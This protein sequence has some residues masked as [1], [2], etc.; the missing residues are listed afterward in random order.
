MIV[1]ANCLTL[2]PDKGATQVIQLIAKWLGQHSETFVD[3]ERL[4]EGIRDLRLKDDRITSRATLDSERRPVFPY[5]FCV[6]L[7]HKD[8]ETRGRKW[9]TELGLQQ[10]SSGMPIACSILLKTDEVSARVLTPI[11]VTR[12][13]IVLDLVQQCRAISGTPGMAVKRLTEE[14]ATGYSMEIDRTDRKHPIVVVS[15]EGN[16]DY[17]VEPDRLRKVLI[18]LADIVQIPSTV[19][20]FELERKI[21]RRYTAFGGAITIVFPTRDTGRG[22]YCETVLLKTDHL[23]QVLKD[24]GSIESEVLGSVTHRTNLPHSWRH[25]SLESVS[26]ASLRGQMAG[27][28]SRLSEAAKATDKSHTLTAELDKYRELLEQ[29]FN[30]MT[31]KDNSIASLQSALDE[32]QS[33]NRKLKADNDGL[34]FTLSGQ[35]A[36][37]YEQE[38]E[39][40]EAMKP[41][42]DAFRAVLHDQPTLVQCLETIQTLF[43]DRVRVLNSAFDSAR[44]SDRRG[45]KNG[46]RAFHLLENLCGAYWEALSSGKGDQQAKARFG[47]DGYAAVESAKLS[48]EGKKR[49][50]FFYRGSDIFM[51]KHLRDGVKDSLGETLRIHFEWIAPE[52]KI[53]IG[54][55]GKH[56]DF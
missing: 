23:K 27:A 8:L 38:D 50:T 26:E 56:L 55:C 51:E 13:R 42:R 52:K 10:Q 9:I 31:E 28:I 53:V 6:R 5:S 33:L 19:N 49:R 4:A 22:A 7:S 37:E 43:G 39:L 35:Q 44:E 14:S 12:P 21:G 41:F 3:A 34:K 48:A 40:V 11:Q 2:E 18:G 36:A 47:K 29:A 20:S 54:H 45:F 30:A 25:I 1:Y 15:S 16:G 24:D 17:L 32:Q 46:T